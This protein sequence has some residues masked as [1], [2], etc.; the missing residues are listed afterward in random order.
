MKNNGDCREIGSGLLPATHKF[1]R[2]LLAAS[3][4]DDIRCM[5]ATSFSLALALD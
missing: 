3:C 1:A 4:A 5:L 2:R